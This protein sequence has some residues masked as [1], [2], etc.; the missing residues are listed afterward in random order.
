MGPPFMERAIYTINV[1]PFYYLWY[2][3][4][5]DSIATTKTLTLRK[6]YEYASELGQFSHFH[7]KKLLFLSIFCWSLRYFVGTNDMIQNVP[8]KLLKTLGGGAL[9]DTAR[10]R[11]CT[12]ELTLY[13]GV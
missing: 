8:T 2:D 9:L 7:I 5:N 12:S 1:V 4:I 11:Q 3:A 6:I 13:V 10:V